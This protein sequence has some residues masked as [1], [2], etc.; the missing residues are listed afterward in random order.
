[1]ENHIKLTLFINKD[2]ERA[3]KAKQFDAM[4]RYLDITLVNDDGTPC[5]LTGHSAQFNCL[6]A[7]ETYVINNCTITSPTE[8]K[9]TAELTDQTLAIGESICKCDISLF[10]EG[11]KQ[12][13]STRTFFVHVQ[14]SVRNDDAIESANEYGAVQALFQDIWEVYEIVHQIN[15]RFGELTDDLKEGQQKAG[16][17]ALGALNNIWHYLKTQSTAHVVET[18][19]NIE[20]VVGSTDSPLGTDTIMGYLKLIE[21]RGIIKQKQYGI[22]TPNNNGVTVTIQNPYDTSKSMILLDGHGGIYSS[23]VHLSI[24][25]PYISAMTSTGFTVKTAGDAFQ[26]VSYQFFEFY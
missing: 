4:S 20:E 6:K 11:G 15:S 24:Y 2:A 12:I 9:L 23:S 1:M 10:S 18:V 21:K 13:L 5:D 16:S 14:A 19:N 3:I 25:M 26:P 8:G 22:I 17:S 7:D